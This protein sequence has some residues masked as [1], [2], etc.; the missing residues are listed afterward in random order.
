[1]G[2]HG[3]QRGNW[4]NR[5][6]RLIIKGVLFAFVLLI[7]GQLA[8]LDPA[9]RERFSYTSRL[10]GQAETA[11]ARMSARQGNI[12]LSLLQYDRLPQAKVRVNGREVASFTTTNVTV[13][14]KKGDLLEIDG[15]KLPR[16]V[17]FQVISASADVL[18]PPVGKRF[19]AGGNIV[20][21]GIVE[22]K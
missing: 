19:V 22:M 10:E 5:T 7:A 20:P 12:T 14:V 18:S 11:M 17:S 1:M 13:K 21:L 15:T 3:K 4:F 6:E 8:L 9:L 16:T 2:R